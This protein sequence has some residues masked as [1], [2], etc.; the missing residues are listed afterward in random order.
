MSHRESNGPGG[1]PVELRRYSR[2]ARF[3]PLGAAGQTQLASGS[4]LV[5]GCGALGGVAANTLVRAGVGRVVLVD[6]DF[7]ELDNLQRQVLF[8]EDDVGQPKAIR[9]AA[10]LAAINRQVQIEPHVL[11]LSWQNIETLVD[12][13]DVVIDGTDNFETRFLIN[14]AC[15]H[16][17]KPWVFG[18]CLGSEGQSMTIVPG[19]TACLHCLM[20]EGPPPPGTTGTCDTAGILASVI[21]VIASIQATEAIKIL[22]GNVNRVSR[23]LTIVDVW[24]NRYSK[25][26]L[27]TL[28]DQ[29]T[30][31][32]CDGRRFD[33]LEGRRGSQT[34][35]LCGRN[36]VQL[37][38]P[39]RNELDLKNVA[40]RWESLGQV[41]SNPYLVR[42]DDGE[43]QVTLFPDGR[44][45]VQGT[46]DEAVAR[47]I[48]SQ[49]VGV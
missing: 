39:Q 17:G 38:F 42:L 11:H 44:A 13:V 40:R 3:A 25:M 4:A 47:R 31:P 33:W 22:S 1:L 5:V 2:Q 34:A 45:I 32:V 48:Y 37:N 35:V 8:N 30:C 10:H 19:L 26:D 29:V 43:F 18:G 28:R 46:Q 16:L 9:A 27:A 7:V 20:L 21:N 14:D 49:Y 41:S 15:V 24:D 36:A 23:Q 6:R 12:S